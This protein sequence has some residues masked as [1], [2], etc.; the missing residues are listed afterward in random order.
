MPFF[1]ELLDKKVYD[2]QGKLMGRLKDLLVAGDVAYPPITALVVGLPK[3]RRVTVPWRQV[4][5][6]EPGP[7]ILSNSQA[8]LEPYLAS[9]ADLEL[10]EYVLDKQIVDTEG[11]K[12][13]RVNDLHLVKTNGEYRLAAVDN[14]SSGLLRRLGLGRI[15]S[16][17][18]SHFPERLIKW[19]DVDLLPSPLVTVKLRAPHENLSRLHPADIAEILNQLSATEGTAALESL[20]DEIAAKAVAETDPELQVAILE[21]I[22][23]ERAADIL[24]EMAPDDAADVLQDISSEKADELLQLMEPKAAQEARELMAYPEDSAGGLMTTEFVALP[25]DLSAEGVINRLRELAPDAET[26]YYLYVTDEAGHLQG[27]ISLRDLVVAP[28]QR[29][30]MEFMKEVVSVPVS[31]DKWEVA[32]VLEKYNLL[33]VP[34]VD[35]ERR[36]RGTITADDVMEVLMPRAWRRKAARMMS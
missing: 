9:D 13:V 33:A 18:G 16:R 35:S 1:S 28:P 24:E 21:G 2:S 20:D 32:R 8:E 22:D 27:V 15:V 5:S 34:V 19:E 10:A 11:V 3:R 36:L 25:Q 26:I 17:V 12:V 31:A 23:S 4:K 6:L 7:V 29:T 14:T 30:I